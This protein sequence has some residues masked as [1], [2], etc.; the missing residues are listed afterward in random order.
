MYYYYTCYWITE[1]KKKKKKTLNSFGR[2]VRTTCT[3]DIYIERFDDDVSG[4]VARLCD[5]VLFCYSFSTLFFF[6]TGPSQTQ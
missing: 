4:C 5:F 3:G 1:S 6:P 2:G